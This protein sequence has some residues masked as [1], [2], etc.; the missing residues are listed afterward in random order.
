MDAAR[1][2]VSNPSTPTEAELLLRFTAL[3]I[4][5]LKLLSSKTIA[6]AV[7]A[8]KALRPEAD[9]ANFLNTPATKEELPL[10]VLSGKV[11]P[12]VPSILIVI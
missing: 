7:I 2:P 11:I 8:I 4:I 12:L 5:G 9:K 10:T 6:S 1:T 3:A